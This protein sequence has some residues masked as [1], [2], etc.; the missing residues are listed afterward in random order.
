MNQPDLSGKM[1][2]SIDYGRQVILWSDGEL[3][4]DAMSVP[5]YLTADDGRV[6]YIK[7]WNPNVEVGEPLDIA[8]SL[9]VLRNSVGQEQ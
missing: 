7:R 2:D 1:D 9:F 8:A 6:F 3:M 5:E 4:S